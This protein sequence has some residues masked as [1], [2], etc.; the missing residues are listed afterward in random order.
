MKRV[1]WVALAVVVLLI[2][3]AATQET[4]RINRTEPEITTYRLDM[5]DG[6]SLRCAVV[7]WYTNLSIDCDWP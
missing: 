7:T 3:C 1:L 2:L 6:S 4:P 5:E